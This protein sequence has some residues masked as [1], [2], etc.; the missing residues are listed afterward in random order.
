[1][2]TPKKKHSKQ[3]TKIRFYHGLRLS[4]K[5][6]FNKLS[7]VTCSNCGERKLNHRVCGKCGFYRGMRIIKEKIQKENTRLQ[8]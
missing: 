6:L 5:K 4:V 1:M 3:R 8:A 7:I 2:A